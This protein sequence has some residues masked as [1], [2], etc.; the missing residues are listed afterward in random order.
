MTP[1]ANLGGDSGISSYES[2]RTSITIEFSTG[3][4][5]LYDY[6][7][8]GSHHVEQMK[9]LADAGQGLNSYIGRNVRSNYAA[10]LR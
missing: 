8:P 10:K 4:V 3:A 2:G 5:Y 1:Y 6:S 7:K 9:L